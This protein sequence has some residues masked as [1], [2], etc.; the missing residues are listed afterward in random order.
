MPFKNPRVKRGKGGGRLNSII[1][2][3]INMCVINN[4]LAV[5]PK[6]GQDVF[7]SN[8]PLEM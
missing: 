7:W 1:Y 3:Y 2:G 8:F 5:L 4:R 6:L